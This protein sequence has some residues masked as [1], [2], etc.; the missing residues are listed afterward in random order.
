M[1]GEQLKDPAGFVKR[2][3]QMLLDTAKDGATIN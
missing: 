3:N 1:A 2:M